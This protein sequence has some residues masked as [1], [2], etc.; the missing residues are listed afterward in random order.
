M[1]ERST[2]LVQGFR[3]SVPY[4]NA[5][6][7][8]TFVVMLGGEA[9]EHENFAN[10]VNDIGL[11]HS[12]GIRLVLVYG[13]RPQ[14]DANLSVHHLEP[15]YHKH[16]RV[17][18]APT[19]ELVKQAAGLL[20]LDITARLSMSLNNTPLQGA[21]INVVSGN[22]I[23]AQPLGVDDGVDYCHSGRIRRIDDEAIHRQLDSGAI[24]LL[25]P[26]AVSVTGESFNLTSEEVATQLAIKL[27]AEKIIGF[28]SS[29]GVCDDK[30]EIISELF[31]NEAQ[32]RIDALE[33]KG[34][35]HSG[36]VRFLR[37]A[38]KACRSGVRRCHLI[39]YQDD[40]AL[41]QELFSREGIGTQIVMESAEQVRRATINDIGGILELIRPLEQQ[42]ILVRRSREQL[43]MEIDKFTI[44][45]R[46]NL[47]IACAALYPFPE[48]QL[49]EMA[50]V[51]VHPDYRSSSRGEMLL[52]RITQQARQMGLKKLF[53]LTTRSIHW[54]QERG[55][56]PAEVEVLPQQ[57]QALY[58]YHRRSK[59]LV[60]DLT[61]Q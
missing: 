32:L 9:I 58:N 54:F 20:Q 4:I 46:D 48:E 24:V 7:G 33:K 36:T 53:V 27:K 2:E 61:G 23:I 41:V 60:A 25:G 56:T 18:D 37:G 11:L 26:V 47:T 22:F 15:I 16:T 21:H 59:I 30:G 19:L 44:I 31:P 29:Q 39:S 1:K 52:Q 51:A 17:T 49:G 50:C 13:A 45:E 38:V 6:R 34:D 5:H 28:C 35:Y 12:L 43:E 57:K 14:I 40:G 55:F 3:H 10:I 42:G 8:K